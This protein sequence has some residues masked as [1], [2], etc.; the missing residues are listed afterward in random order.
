MRPLELDYEADVLPLTPH[1]NATERHLCEAFERKAAQVFPQA[2]QRAA[3]WQEKLGDAPAAGARLQNLIRA[4]TMKKGGAGYVQPGQGS[5]PLMADM[6]R[7]V[8]EAGAIPTLT[9]LDGTSEGEQRFEEL[10]EVAAAA[11]AAALNLIPDRNYTPGVKDQKLQNLHQVVEIAQKRQFP[12]IV[13]T[14]M[15]APGN[16]FVDS[17]QTAELAPLL[18][19]FLRGARIVYAHSVLEGQAGLGYLSPWARKTFDCVTVKNEF[20][21]KLGQE[22]TPKTEGRLSGLTAAATPEQILA[23]CVVHSPQSTVHGPAGV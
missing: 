21:D 23:R 4:R 6:N 10:F 11:G 5:F 2:E 1:G 18:P 3:F 17:F 16:K 15:N 19:V 14:E 12:I 8:L 22:L 9:W 20:F 7:F 13:G